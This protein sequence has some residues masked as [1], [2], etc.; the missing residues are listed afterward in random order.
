MKNVRFIIITGLSGSG[1]SYAI[2]CFEDLGFF[3]ID[4]LPTTLLLKFAELSVQSGSDIRKVALGIDVREGD[5]FKDTIRVFEEMKQAGYNIEILFLETSDEVLV[6]RYSETR[7]KHPL[8]KNKSVLEGIHLE[9]KQLGSLREMANKIIDTTNY[10][11]HDLKK[12]IKNYY[13]KR[14][15]ISDIAISLISFGYKYGIPYD[16]DLIF[17]VR[18]LPNPYFIDELKLCTGKDKEVREYILKNLESKMFLKK[19]G[20]FLKFLIPLY[21]K[22]GKA[23]LTIAI[24]CTGGRHRSVTIV[25]E[26]KNILKRD[27][28]NVQTVNRNLR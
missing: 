13:L 16:A 11:V 5:F 12:A 24:G 6:R 9:R 27:G 23:Y 15:K 14:D 2:K 26:I 8:A 18:F 10:T 17:D 25:D 1:K 22:E 7:R 21:V 28:Y 20:S 4:N 3:C 19:L